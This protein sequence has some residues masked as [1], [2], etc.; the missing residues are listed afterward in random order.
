[1]VG[2]DLEIVGRSWSV[3]DHSSYDN[4]DGYH[5]DE[6]ECERSDGAE[7]AYLLRETGADHSGQERWFFTRPIPISAI[8]LEGGKPFADVAAGSTE[9]P[10]ALV[11]RGLAH[12]FDEQT[13]G[14]YRE[15]PGDEAGKITWDYWDAKEEQNLAVERWADGRIDCYYGRRIDPARVRVR[16][17]AAPAS[18]LGL[19]SRVAGTRLSMGHS[20]T[21]GR[22]VVLFVVAAIG[23]VLAMAARGAPIDGL[24][25]V[26]AVVALLL[27]RLLFVSARSATA[28]LA[29]TVGLAVA[30]SRFPPL[31]SIA[32]LA[33][34]AVV[35]AGIARWLG[36]AGPDRRAVVRNAAVAAGIATVAA[37]LYHFY[38]FAP[39]PPSAGQWGLAVGPAPL[40]AALAAAIAFA[41]GRLSESVEGR[42]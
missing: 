4:A 32:G 38:R 16:E 35:P 29:A 33:L 28:W 3:S 27:A 17:A 9:P 6:W 24:S 30:F 2:L 23:A 14:T 37:G 15:D 8:T 1:M 25:A 18:G 36:S 34:L 7:T 26:I 11:Y 13:D 41:V 40:A 5:V 22:A 31:S 10:P 39:V 12:G 20:E 42:P 21:V 19:V